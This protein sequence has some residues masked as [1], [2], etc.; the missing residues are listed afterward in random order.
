MSSYRF[1]TIS[2]AVL[3]PIFAAELEMSWNANKPLGTF[4]LGL[5]GQKILETGG[6]PVASSVLGSVLAPFERMNMKTMSVRSR[7]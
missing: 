5:L 6:A 2:E 3:E 1:G 4:L 7:V